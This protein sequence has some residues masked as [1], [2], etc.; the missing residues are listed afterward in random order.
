VERNF[1]F[2]NNLNRRDFWRIIV[3]FCICLM[4]ENPVVVPGL[5]PAGG[6]RVAEDTMDL[7]KPADTNDFNPY[8]IISLNTRF[9]NKQEFF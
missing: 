9:M 7:I 1:E 3:V 8:T 4:F 5:Q 6:F 2:L